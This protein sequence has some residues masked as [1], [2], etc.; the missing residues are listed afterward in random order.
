MQLKDIIDCC[1]HLKT[2]ESRMQTDEF[3]DLVFYNED[4]PEWFRILS[5]FLGE[6]VKPE[7]SEPTQKDLQITA[8]TGS[9]RVEQT[10]FEK[11][12]GHGVILAKFWPWKD[13]QHTTLRMALLKK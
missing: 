13:K 3:V 11:E 12:Y 10:L 5:S 2:Y 8:K 6:P 1:Q 4:L 7:G 9:I